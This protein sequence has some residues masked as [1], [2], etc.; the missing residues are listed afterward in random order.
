[1]PSTSWQRNLVAIWLA[2][3]VAITGNNIVMAILPL[4]VQQLGV[5]SERQVR[6]W[7]GAVFAAHAVTMAVFVPIWGALSDRYGRKVMVVRAMLCAPLPIT[8]MGLAQNVQQLTLLPALQGALSV[9]IPASVTLVATTVPR[10]RAGHALGLLLIATYGR[11]SAGPLLGGLIADTLGYPMA[12]LTA[13]IL[14]LL[15]A[16]GALCFVHEEFRPAGSSRS[17][18]TSTDT[19]RLALPIR[20]RNRLMPVLRS[21]LLLGILGV[22][23]IMR[24]G[25]HSA[26][27]TLPLF[28]LAIAPAGARVASI[29]GLINGISAATGAV[30]A[31]GL[32][33]LGDRVGYGRVLL[34]RAILSAICYGAQVFIGSITALLFL[35]A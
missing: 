8:F 27:P 35:Q 6:I 16:L 18:Q 3:L 4:Y 33:R 11:A 22:R 23:L 7:A 34:G 15:A 13:G 25:F 26:R 29:A 28:I 5:Q 10:E 31:W 30:G 14:L 19:S 17:R 2:Q 9:V 12:F 32:G 1:M 20:M 24:W 21:P